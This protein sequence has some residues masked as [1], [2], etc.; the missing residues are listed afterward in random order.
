MEIQHVAQFSAGV[1]LPRVTASETSNHA[2]ASAQ[3]TRAVHDGS[4][5]RNW[6]FPVALIVLGAL[7]VLQTVSPLRLESDAV[8]YLSTGAA[9]ADGRVTP[10]MPFPSGYPVF[11]G[12]LDRAGLGSSF[13]F[14]LANC[15]FL[16]LGIWATW[17][18]FSDRPPRVR[19]WIVVATLLAISVVR[20]VAAPLPEAAF[21]GTS[22]LALAAMTEAVSDTGSKRL[23]LFVAALALS[24]MAISIRLVGVALI[25]TLF[26][27]SRNVVSVADFRASIDADA[28]R[29]CFSVSETNPR[30]LTLV[31]CPGPV[32]AAQNPADRHLRPSRLS[33]ARH[34]VSP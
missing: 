27:A 32:F 5:T 11:V 15:P 10:N 4:T 22:L 21:F 24:G 20:S 13:Y 26:W 19:M 6:V 25:P 14:I 2:D 30:N 12:W 9:I 33:P 7:Y 18:L 17:R 28:S 16:G 8:D 3:F 31:P 1:E 34:P 23:L 29:L